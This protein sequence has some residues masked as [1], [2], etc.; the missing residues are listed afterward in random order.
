MK[1]VKMPRYAKGKRPDFFPDEPGAQRML[2]MLMALVTEVGVL[3]E[4]LD[5]VE[6][7]AGQKGLLTQA[8]I[9]SFEPTIEQREAREAWRQA[10]LDRILQVLSDE[11]QREGKAPSW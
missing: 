3:R 5:T 10:Y 1:S 4:R 7:L 9:E 2:S 11:V 8:E 6:Q